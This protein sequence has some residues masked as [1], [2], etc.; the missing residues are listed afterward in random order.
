MMTSAVAAPG[1]RLLAGP[2]PSISLCTVGSSPL[3]QASSAAASVGC[4]ALLASNSSLL[5]ASFTPP[6]IFVHLSL[7]RFCRAKFGVITR[8]RWRLPRAIGRALRAA[9]REPSSSFRGDNF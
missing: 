2:P 8:F 4:T 6:S 9:A 7:P 3:L 1:T 5:A